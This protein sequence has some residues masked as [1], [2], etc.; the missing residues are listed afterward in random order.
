MVGRSRVQLERRFRALYDRTYDR[1][2]A[3]VLRRGA[4]EDE[5]RDVV[6]DTYMAVWRRMRDIPDDAVQED[7][8]VFGTARRVLANHRRASQ[9][10]S[11]LVRRLGGLRDQ[12]A[13]Y[14]V[15]PDDRLMRAFAALPARHR[16]VLELALW[17]DLENRQ[18]ARILGC[19]E[20]A[21]SIRLHRARAALRER[22]DEFDDG[23]EGS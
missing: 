20:N 12:S 4:T 7:A 22:Y 13:P 2:W 5:T 8:W 14:E 3:F 23:G 19:S 9:R 15:D 21:V 18:I 16:E 1:V 17:D 11:R 6:G 10:R